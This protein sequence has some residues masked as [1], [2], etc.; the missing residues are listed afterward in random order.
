MLAA[1]EQRFVARDVLLSVIQPKELTESSKEKELKTQSEIT[2]P[3]VDGKT[4]S[5]SRFFSEF[6][7]PNRYLQIF[8]AYFLLLLH[9]PVV[10][11]NICSEWPASHN[12]VMK[13]DEEGCPN[14]QYFLDHLPSCEVN[15]AV[16]DSKDF[17]D[18][19]RKSIT[20]HEFVE[21]WVN[22]NLPNQDRV[23]V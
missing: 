22:H 3:K 4:L 18:Q 19:T 21:Y 7:F 12:W 20:L 6:M 8:G 11:Q 16:C 2:I 9:R 13:S 15:V 1:T 14:L 17:S 10:I 5:Y 23:T